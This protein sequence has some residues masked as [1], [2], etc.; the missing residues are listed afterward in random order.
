MEN[1]NLDTLSISE[2]LSLIVKE[3][4]SYLLDLENILFLIDLFNKSS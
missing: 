3:F 1:P 2:T 4:G